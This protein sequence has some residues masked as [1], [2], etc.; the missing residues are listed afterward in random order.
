MIMDQKIWY[1]PVDALAFYIAAELEEN[2][3]TWIQSCIQEHGFKESCDYYHNRSTDQPG[4]LEYN[5][6]TLPTAEYGLQFWAGREIANNMTG[7]QKELA[8]KYLAHIEDYGAY[9]GR[10][11][12]K[13]RTDAGHYVGNDV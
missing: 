5:L 13:E 10:T 12:I 6:P 7:R 11:V 2:L 3:H 8:L 1:Y 9:L 4:P